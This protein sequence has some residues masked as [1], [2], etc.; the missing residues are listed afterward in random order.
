VGGWLR[1][2]FFFF[3][4]CGDGG[5]FDGGLFVVF[6]FFCRWGCWGG[7]CFCVCWCLR[8][9]WWFFSGGFFFF[10]GGLLFEGVG[11]VVLFVMSVC[12][13]NGDL[14]LM[15][16]GSLVRFGV[17]LGLCLVW[18]CSV[19]VCYFCLYYILGVGVV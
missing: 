18:G 10:F 15:M 17:F 9:G 19:V 12:F 6:F 7:V 13:V 2:V 11:C 4:G 14:F 5:V 1:S 3:V 8:W 16:G